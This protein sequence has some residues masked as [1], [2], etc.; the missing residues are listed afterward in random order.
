MGILGKSKGAG[1]IVISYEP[2]WKTMEKKKAT[3]YT[4]RYKGQISGATVQR[5]Q[6]GES[7]STNT[8]DSICKLL[9]CRVEDVIIYL[10]DDSN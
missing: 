7:V 5:L 3:T 6:R 2:L 8:I 10:D 4:L 9:N 1:A